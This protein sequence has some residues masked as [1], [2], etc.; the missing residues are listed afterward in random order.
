MTTWP[1]S[2]GERPITLVVLADSVETRFQ[3]KCKP[4]ASHIIQLYSNTMTFYKS[5]KHHSKDRVFCNLS[6]QET[7]VV[8]FCK[9]SR[10]K[11][12]YSGRMC[13]PIRKYFFLHSPLFQNSILFTNKTLFAPQCFVVYYKAVCNNIIFSIYL[14][15][16]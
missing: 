12:S 13:F 9:V 5:F 4:N 7:D 1:C 10:P 16:S 8:V 6:T 14:L 3:S 11:G 2:T 15:K